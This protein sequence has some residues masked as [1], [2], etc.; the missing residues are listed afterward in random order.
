M[1]NTKQYMTE[2][3]FTD[4]VIELAQYRRWRV[5]HFRPA[6][7]VKGWRTAIQGDKGFPDLVLARDGVVIF[8]ELKTV[9]GSVHEEQE[10]WH[11][12]LGG[13]VYIWRPPDLLRVIPEIL[14]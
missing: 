8:A 6:R 11:T 9:H 7:T 2:A 3:Q 14:R 5:C 10:K 12:A 1:S 13:N 4:A